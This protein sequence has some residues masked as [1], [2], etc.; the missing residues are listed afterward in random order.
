MI[1][2]IAGCGFVGSSLKKSFEIKGIDTKVYDKFKNLDSCEDLLKCDIIFL[3]LPTLFNEEINQYDKS[4]IIEMSNFLNKNSY[5][6]TIVIKS[7]VEPETTNKLSKQFENLKFAHN[8]EFLTARTAF[9]DFHNQKH[10]VLGKGPNCNDSD[11][12]TIYISC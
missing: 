12:T 6:G 8:P 11:I 9:D 4:A 5:K 1:I 2:G 10:I 7:T 3:C